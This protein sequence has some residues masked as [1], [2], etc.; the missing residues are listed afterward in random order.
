MIT[1]AQYARANAVIDMLVELATADG[2]IDRLQPIR[3]LTM[4]DDLLVGARALDADGY[5][6]GTLLLVGANVAPEH[7]LA[8]CDCGH[9]HVNYVSVR[10]D[11]SFNDPVVSYTL[12]EHLFA[13]PGVKWEDARPITP[14][15]V[16][17]VA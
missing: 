12:E 15:E 3:M 11:G 2:E 16:A 8:D 9:D 17:A 6:D 4:P 7:A 13:P 10:A 5:G 14:E 1:A